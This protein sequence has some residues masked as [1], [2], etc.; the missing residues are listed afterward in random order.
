MKSRGRLRQG[1]LWKQGGV[2]KNWNW[3]YFVASIEFLSYYASSSELTNP[4]GQIRISGATVVALPPKDASAFLFTVSPAESKRTYLIKAATETDRQEWI[5]E[6]TSLGALEQPF[7]ILAGDM[8]A[9]ELKK[10][11]MTQQ[12]HAGYMWK[13]G[14]TVKNWKRRYFQ[15]SNGQLSYFV[16]EDCKDKKGMIGVEGAVLTCSHRSVHGP[17]FELEPKASSRVFCLESENEATRK[18]WIEALT[19]HGAFWRPLSAKS[20]SNPVVVHTRSHSRSTSSKTSP[21]STA[22]TSS[23]PRKQSNSRNKDSKSTM[24]PPRRRSISETFDHLVMTM[25]MS[26]RSRRKSFNDSSASA[27][28]TATTAIPQSSSAISSSALSP[29]PAS[30]AFQG[31]PSPLIAP[32]PPPVSSH[33][34][35]GVRPPPV[36]TSPFSP[37]AAAISNLSSPTSSS[38]APKTSLNPR[39]SYLLVT[40]SPPVTRSVAAAAAAASPSRVISSTFEVKE[41]PSNKRCSP[42]QKLTEPK[43]PRETKSPQQETSEESI[44]GALTRTKRRTLEL[45]IQSPTN[46]KSPRF[47]SEQIG[48][49]TPSSTRARMC[50]PSRPP[51]TPSPR[52][53]NVD[54]QA[55][56]PPSN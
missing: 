37:S 29:L 46:Q 1:Y 18:E 19:L 24:S 44:C 31:S 51:P 25:G 15:L 38:S 33:T 17:E 54:R 34:P 4:K 32:P 6:L 55:P 30:T 39:T 12:D 23:L 5:S 50:P 42:R 56:G 2:V 20:S 35:R 21:K 26:T 49:I 3:R 22:S 47:G 16:S 48:S 10:K 28:V 41:S 8:A 40:Y 36:F 13:L 52:S 11:A 45:Q 7:S 9:A 14:D 27:I 53:T 43:K